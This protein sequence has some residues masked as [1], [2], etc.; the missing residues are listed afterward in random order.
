MC[1]FLPQTCHFEDHLFLNH[2]KREN[3]SSRGQVLTPEDEFFEN[4]QIYHFTFDDLFC[5]CSDIKLVFLIFIRNK[6]HTNMLSH[7]SSAK[8]FVHLI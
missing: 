2:Q 3:S 5:T 4:C 8:K 6:S 1:H 7:R